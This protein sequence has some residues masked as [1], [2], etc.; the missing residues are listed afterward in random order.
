MKF[1][2][3][4]GSVGSIA[5]AT[6]ELRISRPGLEALSEIPDFAFGPNWDKE[7]GL[8]RLEKRP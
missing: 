1:I 6:D 5:R 4:L 2:A 8:K 3:G 7:N